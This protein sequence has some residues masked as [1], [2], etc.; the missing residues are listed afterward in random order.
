M[1]ILRACSMT[2]VHV[3]SGSN[4]SHNVDRTCTVL[5]TFSIWSI[6]NTLYLYMINYEDSWSFYS[7]LNGLSLSGE[8]PTK[9]YWGETLNFDYVWFYGHQNSLIETP[10]S[11]YRSAT[12][13]EKPNQNATW[14]YTV[15]DYIFV[16][17]QPYLE[18]TMVKCA[19]VELV[20]QGPYRLANTPTVLWDVI[21]TEFTADLVSNANFD[22]FPDILIEY[23]ICLK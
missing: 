2:N 6:L 23:I 12:V 16:R 22:R 13:E 20:V 15:K 4:M 1:R 7:Q 21:I 9:N 19:W 11:I 18:I 10:L 14:L 17:R 5:Y 8:N 3:L